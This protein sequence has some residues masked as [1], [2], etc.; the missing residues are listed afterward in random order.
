MEHVDAPA[1]PFVPEPQ[2]QGKI[3]ADLSLQRQSTHMYTTSV[4]LEVIWH[5][6]AISG[7][8]Y[9]KNAACQKPCS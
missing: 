6:N 2:P 9:M 1:S 5:A 3:L 4:H 7:A 8:T